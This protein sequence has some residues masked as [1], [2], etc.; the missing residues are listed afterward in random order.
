MFAR[1]MRTLLMRVLL[2]ALLKTAEAFAETNA[3]G[4]RSRNCK[5]TLEWSPKVG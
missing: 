2:S 3:L 1:A 4:L 5:V